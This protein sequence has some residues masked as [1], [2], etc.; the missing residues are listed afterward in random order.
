MKEIYHKKTPLEHILDRPDSY[1][2]SL[3]RETEKLWIIKDNEM[4]YTN[5]N[6]IPGLYKIYDEILV[7]AIDQSVVDSKL[8][9]IEIEVNKAEGWISVC[10]SGS[11][12]PVRKH[13][14]EDLYIVEMIFG[15]LLT[16]SNYD[17]SEKRTV[18]GRNGYGAKLANIF[19]TKFIVETYDI[20]SK[21]KYYQEW[22]NNMT[23]K[24]TP[25]ISKKSTGN[26]FAKFTFFPDF[27]R[28]GMVDLEDDIVSLFEK[29]AYDA[30]A[31]THDSVSVYYNG[32]K[33]SFKNFSKYIDL[34]IGDSKTTPRVLEKNDR[35]EVCVCHSDDGYK[36]ISF[37]NGICTST[38]GEHVKHIVNQLVENITEQIKKKHSKLEIKPAFVKEHMMVFIKS[39]IEN[40]VFTSQTKVELKT[41]QSS[42]GSKFICE[43]L[44][45][46]RVAK[47]GILDDVM[48][49]AKH[50]ELQG[51]SKSDGK[52]KTSLKGFPKLDDANK[53]G[54][55]DS[56]LCTLILTE[57]DSAKTMAVSGISEIKNG[58]DY[59][60]IFPLRGKLLNVRDA[61]PSML[62]KNEEIKALK[63]IIA[64]QQDKVYSSLSELRYGR[65][66]VLTDADVDGSHI[67]GLIFNFIHCF[68]PCLLKLD[69]LK[70][71]QTPII[72]ATKRNEVI[73]FYT[74]AEFDNWKTNSQ[75]GYAIKY[76][77]GLG[78]S[79]ST[80]AKEYFRNLSQNTV[81]YKF[82]ENTDCAIKLAFKKD[83]SDVRKEWIVNGIDRNESLDYSVKEISFNSFINNEL[84]WFSIADVKRSIASLVDGLKPSQRKVIYAMR[85]R[86]N[87]EIKVSQLGGIVSTETAYHHGEQSLYG[88]IIN[89][90]QNFVGSN[91][92]NLLEPKGQFGT[93]LQGGKDSASP[94]YIFTKLS[95]K[96]I[97]L[98]PA[99]DDKLL[100]Y[101]QDD[102]LKIEPEYFVPI[103]PLVL[104]NGTEGIGTGYSSSIP[105][106]NP[107]D[108]IKGVKEA[109]EG[110]EISN[111]IPWYPN[112]LGSI[113]QNEAGN[114]FV[115][116]G[117]YRITGDT[118]TISELPIGRWTQ[119][120]KEMLDHMVETSAI[121]SYE[122]HS[123][124]TTVNF[125]IKLDRMKLQKIIN[126][127][128]IEK[129][130]KLTTSLSIRNMHLFNG[131]NNITKYD[132]PQQI[133]KEFVKV[134]LDFY[135]KRKEYL[136]SQL[137][138][139]LTIINEKVRFIQM[140]VEEK[141]IIFKQKKADIVDAL[142][143][144]EFF[145][146]NDNYDYLIK[147][148]LYRL[149]SDSID[150]LLKEQTSKK[151]KRKTIKQTSV[152]D[153]WKNELADF[154]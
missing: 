14:T 135:N 29:R 139:E 146:V 121:L 84:V 10:N 49:L 27:T 30:C 92:I 86:N 89:L 144:F 109:I 78:T 31:C 112:F 143:K 23:T 125:K 130:F 124:D 19:S 88:T 94:R 8:D 59:Y 3:E 104:I 98:F 21:Q 103:V 87:K 75:N 53:A 50:K 40:P 142:K 72:K 71:F 56:A 148:E 55:K 76:Y 26:G 4:V 96:C 1:V 80:E 36:Q 140:V 134:R 17:D 101:L 122:N 82:D 97:S 95:Q 46:T 33:L 85:K 147:I 127:R 126:T 35:W 24:S 54:T 136:L 151:Q 118:I 79:T 132:S 70:G 57:G 90:A 108:I 107:K 67:K 13:E 39:T 128:T 38:G 77:K 116:H 16:S 137:K 117:V 22:T 25:K 12:I 64:L 37:V 28:F 11:G 152:Q 105:C 65:I 138:T 141:I 61:T 52:K 99:E 62:L 113:V 131:N 41:K 34:Y 145:T 114:G 42:F 120:F 106:Y 48:A 74:Q 45:S 63:Q 7:N 111:M 66:M 18:G 123:T 83:L 51:L 100:N 153:L 91:T 32:S 73:P 15:E 149:T 6:Y 43:Q 47:L 2:G 44:F 129:E 150:E 58:R 119:D 9:K 60:G 68:W 102:G 115:T 93:R 69:I 110:K 5:V 133:I 81:Q 154:D 20:N